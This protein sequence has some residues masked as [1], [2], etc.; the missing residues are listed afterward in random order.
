MNYSFKGYNKEHMARAYGSALNI[1]TKYAV[2]VSRMIRGK[3]LARAKAMLEAV[4]AKE[5]GVPFKRSYGDMAH[6]REIGVGRFPVKCS[7]AILL[8]LNGAEANAQFLGLDTSSLAIKAIIAHKASHVPRYGRKR[9]RVSKSTHL[10]I[11]L[12]E[13]AKK[14]EE[15]KDKKPKEKQ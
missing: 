15:K 2:E 11:I 12:E 10:E 4:I 1:S 3:K 5:K 9:G 13:T 6:Q 8:L 14:S 7:K